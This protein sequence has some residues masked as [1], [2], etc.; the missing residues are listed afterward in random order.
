MDSE[1]AETII[2]RLGRIIE[3]LER[4]APE[5]VEAPPAEIACE[6]CARVGRVISNCPRCRGQGA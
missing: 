6:V 3:L 1:Q 2:E 4:L 5:P